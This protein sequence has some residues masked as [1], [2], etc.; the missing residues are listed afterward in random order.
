MINPKKF[1]IYCSGNASRVIRFYTDTYNSEI[2]FPNV[3]IYDGDVY[4][5]ENISRTAEIHQL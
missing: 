2:F 4:I 3:V 1:A 5:V